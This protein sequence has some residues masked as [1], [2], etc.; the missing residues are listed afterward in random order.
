MPI[1][2]EIVYYAKDKRILNF[3]TENC[4]DKRAFHWM[5]KRFWTLFHVSAISISAVSWNFSHFFTI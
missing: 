2:E 1:S 3:M 5:Q 4:K